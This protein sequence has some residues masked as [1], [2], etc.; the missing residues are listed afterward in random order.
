M[1]LLRR[2]A[3]RLPPALFALCFLAAGPAFA[4]G[5]I[6]NLAAS[7]GTPLVAMYYEAPVRPAPAVVL[8]HMLG[9][10]K[11]EWA[12]FADRLQQSGVNALAIDLRGHGRSGGTDADLGA[13]SAD[14]Q[15]ALAWVGAQPS[16]RPGAIAIVGASLGAN[17]AAIAAASAPI[18][19]AVAL[20]S[21]SL[22][23]RGV[24]LDGGTLRKIGDRP[25]WLAASTEDPYA[26]RSLKELAVD[27][28]G[29]EQHLSA[30]R[31]HGTGLL[32]ADQSLAGA[33]VDWL[34]RTLIF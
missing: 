14:V 8:V 34:R 22:D 15:A 17:L 29:G 26:L 25:L 27:R 23:Y 4:A 28:P 30:I 7:D 18:V 19:R 13:M 21:P 33:L 24:R 32:S 11:D 10:S 31:A 5:R 12:S 2:D 6:V 1:C 3:R 9:R 16:V 20:I